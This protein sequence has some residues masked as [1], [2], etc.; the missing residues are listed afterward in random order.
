MSETFEDIIGDI[1][2]QNQGLP[3]DGYALSPLVV[4]LLRLADRIE[5]A[6]K[7]YNK[8][9]TELLREVIGGMCLHC[10]LQTSCQEGEDGMS[11]TC[12]AV[13]KATH[14]IEQHTEPESGKDLPF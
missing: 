13:A 12:N 14:F 7:S 5:A 4:D 11:T 10:D 8:E 2:A 3:E 9:I 1:R 6:V